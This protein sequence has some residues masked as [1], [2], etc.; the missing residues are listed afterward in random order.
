MKSTAIR[1]MRVTGP[2]TDDNVMLAERLRQQ[3]LPLVVRPRQR[4]GELVPY[5]GPVLSVVGLLLLVQ[6]ITT[7]FMINL[8][9]R[10]DVDFLEADTVPPELLVSASAALGVLIG[11][12][13]GAPLLLWGLSSLTR[14]TGWLTRWSIALAGIATII[15]SNLLDP[16]GVSTPIN[17]VLGVL[18]VGIILVA[19]YLGVGVLLLWAVQRILQELN[20]LGAMVIRVLPLLMLV[21]LFL[22][23][24][25]EIW[26][27][28]A[29]ISWLNVALTAAVLVVLANV[30]NVVTTRGAVAESHVSQHLAASTA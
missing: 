14:R 15:A 25:A 27:I 5:T 8:G 2:G 21:M 13:I 4:R 1:R 18:N 30:L 26:Q 28:A 3:G 16:W 6:A 12:C 23:Y 7:R 17:L 22:F 10:Y 20:S 19:A 29:G 11:S 24:N 9:Q